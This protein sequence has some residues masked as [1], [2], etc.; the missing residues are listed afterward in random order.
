MRNAA[1]IIAA[2]KAQ[3]ES[4]PDLKTWDDIHAHTIK[5]RKGLCEICNQTQA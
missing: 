2:N 4:H 1:E 3:N 5:M